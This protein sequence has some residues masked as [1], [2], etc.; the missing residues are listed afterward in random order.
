MIPQSTFMVLAPIDVGREAELRQLLASMNERP[1]MADP[2]NSVFPFGRFEGLHFARWVILDDQTLDDITAYGAARANLPRYLAFLG[3]CDGS[4][5]DFLAQAAKSAGNGLRRIFSCCEGFTADTV[6]LRWM[7]RHLQQPAAA[8]TNWIGRTVQQTREENA[9]RIALTA[10][11]DREARAV[12]ALSPRQL[13][14]ELRRFVESEQKAGRLSLS[15]PEPTPLGWLLAN[16]MHALG[17]PL[18]LL[19]ISPVLLVYFPAFL[20]QLRRRERHDAEIAPRPELNSVRT[21]AN[22][23]D[24]DV[25]NPFT[26]MGSIKPGLFRRWLLS[27]L[28][29]LLDYTARHIY[30]RGRLARVSTIH[31]A[32]WVFIDG[33]RRMLFA[34]NYDG[35]LESYMDDF[36]NKVAFG[37]NLVFSNGVGYPTTNWLILGGAKDEQKFKYFLRRH[38][39][40][41]QVW[42]NAR[43]GMTTFDLVRNS[44]IRKGLEQAAMTDAQIA[45]WAKLL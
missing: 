42:Y 1:G 38:E 29:W 4:S 16:W 15:P 24:Y 7:N 13:H 31:F 37:L 12:A 10:Y 30:N 8:Y 27:F 6:L 25:T 2:Q 36:I 9:L 19:L 26:A 5:A 41:T 32:R 23:E 3:D 43:P 40:P 33:K 39:L 14:Q 35:S 21:L 45:T 44:L 20:I 34:S 22:L 11:L 18:I 17:V 28:L